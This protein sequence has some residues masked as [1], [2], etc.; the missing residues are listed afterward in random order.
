ML[1]GKRG[2]NGRVG[3]VSIAG[4]FLVLRGEPHG[5]MGRLHKGRRGRQSRR[6]L[7]GSSEASQEVRAAGARGRRHSI[8]VLADGT[9]F[10]RRGKIE[11]FDGIAL[12]A[13]SEASTGHA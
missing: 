5:R 7:W 13:R 3:S 10:G 6:R 1:L 2:T 4:M 11:A 12:A 8:R 9:D